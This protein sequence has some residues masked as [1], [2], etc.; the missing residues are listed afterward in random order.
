LQRA[1]GKTDAGL[2]KEPIGAAR[3][4]IEHLVRVVAQI[5]P[6]RSADPIQLIES[7]FY[8]WRHKECFRVGSPL[9]ASYL[10]RDPV[11]DRQLV[12]ISGNKKGKVLPKQDHE[13]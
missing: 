3:A 11:M 5:S 2:A 6:Q 4:C 7:P 8:G 12:V 9:L 10:P 13:V 1:D